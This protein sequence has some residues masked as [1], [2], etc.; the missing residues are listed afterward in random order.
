MGNMTKKCNICGCISLPDSRSCPKCNNNLYKQTIEL[1]YTDSIN[2]DAGNFVQINE[3]TNN[4]HISF[5]NI[6][7]EL[8]RISIFSTL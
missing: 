5:S 3:I 7:R 6:D 8:C 2:R 1:I 4:I